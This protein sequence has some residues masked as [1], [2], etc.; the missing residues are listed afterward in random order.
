MLP[1]ARTLSRP[2]ARFVVVLA[3]LLGIL[4]S[5]QAPLET[6]ADSH[7]KP[8]QA[9]LTRQI[10]ASGDD[11]NED[12]S[13]YVDNASTVWLGTGASTTS[14]YT[15]LRFTNVTVPQGATITSAKVQ[16]YLPNLAWNQLDF[17][18]AAENVGNS[19]AF[20]TSNRPSQ[21]T[22]TTQ[23]VTHSSNV[24]W[25][26]NTWIDLDEI[27]TVV[28]PVINRGDWASGNALSLVLK[29]SGG[30][31]ARVF[32]TAYDGTPAN[33]VRLALTYTTGGTTSTSTS[34][35]T[36]TSTATVTRTPTVTATGSGGGTQ[37]TRQIA[38]SADDVNEDGSSYVD[39]SSTVWLGNA[40]STTA[41]YTGL[42]F[43]S[44]TIPQG[45]TITSAKLQVFVPS[46]SWNQLDFSYAAENAGNSAAFT[47]ANRPSQ[48]TLTTQTV[49]HS[50]DVNW[51]ANTWI[52]L[53]EIS[54]VVQPVIGR[55]DWASGNALSIILR[56]TGTAY[57]RKF[58]TA[59]DG[60]PANAIRLVIVYVASTIT[61]TRTSTPST[62]PTRTQTAT[63]TGT[64]TVTPTSTQLPSVTPTSTSTIVTPVVPPGQG[65]PGPEGIAVVTPGSMAYRVYLSSIQKLRTVGGIHL[66]NRSTDWNTHTDF[67]VRLRPGPD[68]SFPAVVVVLSD[69][70]FNINR[71]TSGLCK[72]G[73]VS[74]RDQYAYDY[75]TLAQNNSAKIIF[76]IYPSPG[77]FEDWSGPGISHHL[78]S[79]T[80]PAGGDYCNG[81]SANFRAVDDIADEMNAI[82]SFNTAHNWRPE[83]IFFE[84]ANEPNY[85]W[86][87]LY[88]DNGVANLRPFIDDVVAWQEMDQYFAGIYDQAK[89]RNA[90]ISVLA[91][92]MTQALYAE[93]R[94]NFQA[95]CNWTQLWVNGNLTATSGYSQMPTTEMTK[96]DGW[97]WHDYWLPG[98]EFWQP[99]YCT[100]GSVSG[101][102]YQAFPSL[103]RDEIAN[104]IKPAFISEADLKSPCEGAVEQYHQIINK[105][106]QVAAVQE[107]IWRFIQQAGKGGHGPDYVAVWLLTN[108]SVDFPASGSHCP[109]MKADSSG[110]TEQAWHEAYRDTT[111]ITGA[112]ERSWFPL[113]WN[114]GEY[115]VP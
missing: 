28:Q 109:E 74:I 11:V 67:L 66:G 62:T 34:T 104:S 26:A 110:N 43:T 103:L 108:E 3:I 86:Y 50:S 96:N 69:Q 21:R 49:A 5:G 29:G 37:V 56:G 16:I 94:E 70:V 90:A 54:S 55:A 77:N 75:L 111:A 99:T 36:R 13:S 53:D 101:H 52:E 38:A 44:L 46:T 112:Y 92:P 59:Y 105:D 45:A 115:L 89:A 9:T 17:I 80:A 71:A 27:Y 33:A 60:T 4:G 39:N 106:T 95:N 19:A 7:A 18:F 48:R 73:S 85:E 25:A 82:F 79:G 83:S 78:L 68:G 65:Y 15:G 47:S 23:T 32:V 113:W 51:P 76:R 24:Q 102:V 10:V 41:S 1:P 63:A 84:P 98:L 87:Q 12:G 2:L 42:R 8:L 14:S 81:K 97:S 93:E 64:A 61:P 100:T 91:P 20:S 88:K 57:A 72:I 31:Y 35:P 6:F 114:R 30:A 40:T 58:V 22:L 107:S